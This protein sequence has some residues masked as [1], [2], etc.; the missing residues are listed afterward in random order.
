MNLRCDAQ[1]SRDTPATVVPDLLKAPSKD[2]NCCASTVQPEVMS[3][4]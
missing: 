1:E 3:L 2:W 4:G